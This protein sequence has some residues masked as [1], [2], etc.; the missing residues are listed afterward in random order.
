MYTYTFGGKKGRKHLLHESDNMFVVR[1]KKGPHINFRGIPKKVL[2]RVNSEEEFPEADVTVYKI[3]PS[4]KDTLK[5]R[6]SA[7]LTLKKDP[8]VRFAGRV[9]VEA[10]GKTIVL[11]TENIFVKFI[12]SLSSKDCEKILKSFNLTIKQKQEY[13]PNSYF[14]S[15]PENTGLE[16]F[17]ISAKLLKMKEVEL[18]HPE[19]IRKKAL[20]TIHPMQ[21]HLIP[22]RVNGHSVKADIS[23]SDALRLST[24]SNVVIALIDDGFDIDHAEFKKKGKV[25][26]PK[27]ISSGSNNP[28]PRYSYENHGTSCA[29]V[30]TARGVNA[31]GVAPGAQLM[32]VRLSSNLGSI[33]E[34]N[35]F[36]WAADNGADIISCS[37]GPADGDWSNPDDPAH[38]TL[39]DLPDSTRLAIDYCIA[40]GRKG[41]GCIIT[42][43]AGNGN[44]DIRYD[45]YASYE[46]VIAVAASNDTDKRSVYSDFGKNVCCSFPSSDLGYKPF[47]HP[48]PLTDGIYTT[49]RRGHEG[50]NPDGDYTDDF[51]GTSSS[52][53]GVAGTIALLLSVNPD[54]TPLKVREILKKTCDKIDIAGGKYDSKG[55]SRFYGYG[56][57]NAF[58]AVKMA[59][60]LKKK[61]PVLRRSKN[62][63]PGKN[64]L[65]NSGTQKRTRQG[66]KQIV[67]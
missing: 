52:C 19:L 46:K 30:A 42:F 48:E 9:L 34:A 56:K 64:L 38:T 62:V 28:R 63:R 49:D 66:S 43:A 40:R 12:D 57:V 23:A 20:K 35:A 50:Y 39:T 11:Y 10:D 67:K 1:L 29:G 65:K 59:I 24:G 17:N 51:G 2:S 27:D 8:G 4:V 25:I 61:G 41:K 18:C 21:W 13:A 36:R 53:P 37:W 22:A 54:L 6:D 45:G 58:R 44:E 47:K 60:E 55:H 5:L 33:S 3:K 14:V 7:R 31:S 15:A 26:F 16:T 32:P